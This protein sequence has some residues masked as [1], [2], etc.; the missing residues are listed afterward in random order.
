MN[1]L[2]KTCYIFNEYVDLNGT[3]GNFIHIREFIINFNK[4]GGNAFLVHRDR[5]NFRTNLVTAY[6]I[7]WPIYPH[8]AWQFYQLTFNLRLYQAGR[9]IVRREMPEV[10]HERQTYNGFGGFL[11]AKKFRLPFVL[12]VNAPLKHE[13]GMQYTNFYKWVGN[14]TEEK[15]VTRADKVITVSASLKTYLL[16]RFNIASNKVEVVP[17]GVDPKIFNPEVSGVDVRHRYNLNDNPVVSFAGSLQRWHG[18]DI[19]LNAAK[20]MLTINPSVKFMIIGSGG[21]EKRLKE[22][23]T[24]NVI[25]TGAV[26]YPDV[27]NYLAASDIVVAPYPQ[28]N[29]FYFSPIKLFE[30]MSVG[31]PI[32]A[33]NIG[34]IGE[35]LE[36]GKTG[37]LIEPG[38][39]D[40]LAKGILTLLEDE[41]LKTKL[42]MNARIEVEKKYSW[43]CN[44]RKIMGIYKGLISK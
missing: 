19:L 5:T 13:L 9:A 12:E 6:N 41:D 20:K 21:E 18:V 8:R 44:A 23:A 43:E 7:K 29:F 1:T 26:N 30:Y 35:V 14:I 36:H 28:I 2:I 17:N 11:L 4:M 32:I 42:G 25:F 34:Q 37:L 39:Y 22:Q 40:E 24:K 10:I 33:S 27:P 3:Q 38:N 31:K 15:I 16:N